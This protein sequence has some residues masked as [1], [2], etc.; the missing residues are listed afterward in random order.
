MKSDLKRYVAYSRL[1]RKA[2]KAKDNRN[3]DYYWKLAMKFF[4]RAEAAKNR[5]NNGT[6]VDQKMG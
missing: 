5:M 1:Y 2:L 6:R 3:A 4:D